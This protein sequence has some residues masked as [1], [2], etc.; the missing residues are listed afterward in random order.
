MRIVDR[1]TVC[2]GDFVDESPLVAIE[3][4]VVDAEDG[5]AAPSSP[6]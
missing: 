5:H 3:E 6:A 2:E 4:A 1:A